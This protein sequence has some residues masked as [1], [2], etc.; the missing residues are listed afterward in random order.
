MSA[1]AFV[2]LFLFDFHSFMERKNPLGLIS[3]FKKAF[4]FED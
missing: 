4:G 3:A 2:F 1:D